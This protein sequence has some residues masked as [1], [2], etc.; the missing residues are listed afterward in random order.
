MGTS[1]DLA[2]TP[3]LS[4]GALQGFAQHLV[5]G[6]VLLLTTHMMRAT[7]RVVEV[8][9]ERAE[10][11]PPEQHISDLKDLLIIYKEARS[12]VDRLSHL[13]EAKLGPW[14]GLALTAPPASVLESMAERVEGISPAA[15][16]R[17]ITGG[18]GS[19]EMPCPVTDATPNSSPEP[20]VQV[21]I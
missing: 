14:G 8:F 3:R 6:D 12:L 10:T 17:K 13:D 11:S 15:V 9:F 18:R 1:S 7:P 19:A 21:L 5:L 16:K 2:S 20:L 4:L